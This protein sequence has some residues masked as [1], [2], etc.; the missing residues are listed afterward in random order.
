MQL[1]YTP[2]AL[3]QMNDLPKRVAERIFDKMDWYIKQPDPLSY[4]K[5]LHDSAI[6]SYRFRIG[7]YRVIADLQGDQLSVLVVLTV[8]HRK[9]VYNIR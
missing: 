4:G 8:K 2:Q 5:K 1:R 3:R 6:G 7:D 9:D